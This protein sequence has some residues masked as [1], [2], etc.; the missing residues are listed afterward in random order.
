MVNYTNNNN[1]N[2]INNDNN[3]EHWFK[4]YLIKL[5]SA[6]ALSAFPLCNE[7]T[8]CIHSFEQSGYCWRRD[9]RQHAG[10]F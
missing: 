10:T 8:V 4:K 7:E 9:V 3:K 1:N 6:F 5:F 2:Y